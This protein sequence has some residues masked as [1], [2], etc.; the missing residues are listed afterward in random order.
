ML[1]FIIITAISVS[2]QVLD[3]PMW[4]ES[5]ELNPNDLKT[6]R[7]M[8]WE[9]WKEDRMEDETL[10]ME[11]SE[12]TLEFGDVQMHYFIY[13]ADG[14]KPENGYPLYI[15]VHRDGNYV[16]IET[17][18]DFSGDFQIMFNE[19]M[20]DFEEPVHFV[21]PEGELDVQLHP[22]YEWLNFTTMD[23]CDPNY[24]F[25]AAVSYQWLLEQL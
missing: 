10:L 21:L 14:D 13:A 6:Y 18:E 5:T 23:R 7:D 2:A 15:E 17:N 20:I 9:T 4:D 16:D 22:E 25:E 3:A 11:T 1:F 8:V 19:D 12:L 24:Q